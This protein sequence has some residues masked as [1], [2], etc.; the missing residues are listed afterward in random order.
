MI[1]ISPSALAEVEEAFE[2]YE[3]FVSATSLAAHSKRTYLL[4]SEHFV[5]WLKDDFVPGAK[6]AR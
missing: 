4:H 6:L 3:R 5:R 1:R 2:Q